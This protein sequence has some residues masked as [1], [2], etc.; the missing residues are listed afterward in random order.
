MTVISSTVGDAAERV[1][2]LRDAALL[3]LRLYRVT[4][5]LQVIGIALLELVEYGEAQDIVV[6]GGSLS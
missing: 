3:S 4:Q 2:L 6:G 1:V 5:E